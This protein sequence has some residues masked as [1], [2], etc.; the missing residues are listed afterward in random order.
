MK[1]EIDLKKYEIRTDLV[2]DLLSEGKIEGISTSEEQYKAVHVLD[3]LIHEKN[4]PLNKRPGRY[5]TIEF[6]DVTDKNNAKDVEDVFIKYLKEFLKDENISFDK[7]AL[8]VGLGNRDST[9]DSLGPKV[10][11]DVLVTKY[12]FDMEEVTPSSDYRNV[13]CFIP[14][15]MASTG[16]E[17][18]D[19]IE[20]LVSLGKP[21]FLIVVD[22]LASSAISR[23]NQT[24]QI[25]NTGIHPGSGVGNK[26]KELSK[27]TLNIPVISIGVPTVIDAIVLVSDTI[28]F[29]YQHFS[30]HMKNINKNK[31]APITMIDPS[32]C[33]E[34]LTEEEK[35]N[36][37]GH[38]G[39]LSEEELQELIYEVLT[40][41]GYHMVVTPKEVDFIVLKLASLIASGINRTLHKNF[42][43]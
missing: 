9:P 27:E 39:S 28:Q 18:R 6:K 24:I 15:V 12:L 22:A 19:M 7:K 32:K 11:E 42:D 14:G 2:A 5:V 34:E 35:E 17:S 38:I 40:P 23:V 10:V 1:H 4:N 25:S 3:V 29:L 16:F 21:D 33:E 8:I 37:L 26:R 31:L 43:N 41:I 20:S 30:Y 36:L 13:S